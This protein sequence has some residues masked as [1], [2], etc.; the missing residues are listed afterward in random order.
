MSPGKRTLRLLDSFSALLLLAAVV[1][2]AWPVRVDMTS[3]NSASALTQGATGTTARVAGNTS[4]DAIAETSAANASAAD[5]IVSANI[6]SGSRHAPTVR[7]TSPDRMPDV[8]Y[9]PP[10]AFARPAPP[11]S[12]TGAFAGGDTSAT[13]SDPV[14][15]L[16]GIV[17]ANGAWQALVRLSASDH[18]ATLLREGDTRGAYRIVSIAADRVVIAGSGGERTLRLSRKPRND[19][20]LFQP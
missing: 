18:A 10:P 16:Y 20:T 13:G 14:P 2:Y 12:M 6:L 4:S 15:S 8:A 7:Y 19:S 5:A 9:V 1:A 3:A 17:H 11:D